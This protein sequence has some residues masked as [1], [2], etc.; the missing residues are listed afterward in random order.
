MS[1]ELTYDLLPDAFSFM[2]VGC[3]LRLLALGRRT[4]DNARLW[5]GTRKSRE[6]CWLGPFYS[7]TLSLAVLVAFGA[8]AYTWRQEIL[9]VDWFLSVSTIGE[10]GTLPDWEFFVL[11]ERYLKDYY[12][13]S[14][15]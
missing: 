3:W 15:K 6:R 8:V 13:F 5:C 12:F 11:I 14:P 2:I 1:I 9:G 4:R 10:I 7:L